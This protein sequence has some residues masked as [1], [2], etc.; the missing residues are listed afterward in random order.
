MIVFSCQVERRQKQEVKIVRKFAARLYND[1]ATSAD[2]TVLTIL[3][4]LFG[5]PAIVGLGVL[6]VKWLSFVFSLFL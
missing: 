1:R 5:L 3:F 6:F 2:W 4:T